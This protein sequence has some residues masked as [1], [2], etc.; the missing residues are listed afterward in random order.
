MGKSLRA[1]EG[2]RAALLLAGRGATNLLGHWAEFCAGHCGSAKVLG[3]TAACSQN[4][5]VPR[6]LNGNYLSIGKGREG[7]GIS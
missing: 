4:P 5:G 3:E 1:A 2:D 6:T 7:K